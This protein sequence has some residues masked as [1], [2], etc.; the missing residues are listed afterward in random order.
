MSLTRRQALASAAAALERPGEV[1]VAPRLRRLP[2]GRADRDDQ[3]VGVDALAAVQRDLGTVGGLFDPQG[4][5][6][7]FIPG[8][9]VAAAHR[10]AAAALAQAGEAP[11]RGGNVR[12]AYGRVLRT[13]GYT[14][15]QYWYFYYDDVYSYTYP[16]SDFIW[17]AHEGDWENVDVVL[18]GHTHVPRNERVGHGQ[19]GKHVS[20]GTA[21]RHHS[22]GDAV[23]GHDT[24]TS[25]CEPR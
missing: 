13:G 3:H 18:H 22:E 21:A 1:Q 8:G 4:E 6:G 14:V 2:V 24:V 20:G 17:Q 12:T 5:R 19:R 9:L 11:D 7:E 10:L 15:L 23:V 25:R 16:A